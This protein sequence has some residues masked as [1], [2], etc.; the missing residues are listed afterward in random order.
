MFDCDVL[1]RRIMRYFV[2][3]VLPSRAYQFQDMNIKLR[4]VELRHVV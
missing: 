4:Q 2:N 3:F 1:S